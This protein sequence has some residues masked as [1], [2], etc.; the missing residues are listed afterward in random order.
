MRL[1]ICRVSGSPTGAITASGPKPQTP[2]PSQSGSALFV[3]IGYLAVIMILSG[4]FFTL[5][6]VTMRHGNASQWRQVCL[7][8]AEGG[9]DK[10]LAELR[11]DRDAY[12]GEAGTALGDGEFSV[13]VTPQGRDGYRIVS[14]GCIRYKQFVSN[15]ARITAD[16]TLGR[17]GN[18]DNL[19]W[20]EV[21][22]W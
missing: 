22:S 5:L 15:Q 2:D 21:K 14:I 16:L 4:A 7:D 12:R 9:L 6:H 3:V 18:I 19:R 11:E 17:N 13:E 8:M 20:L 1:L 10:A